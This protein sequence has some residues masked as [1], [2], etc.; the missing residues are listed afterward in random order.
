MSKSVRRNKAAAVAEDWWRALTADQ[1]AGRGARRGAL[2]R[3]RRAVTPLEVMQ[4]PEALRLIARLPR[5]PERV[6]TLAGILAYVRET[7]G[8]TVARS[9]GRASLDDEKAIL[10]EVRFRRLLQARNDELELLEAMRRIVRLTSG[11]VNVYDLSY[12]V[13]HWGDRVRK[14]WIFDYYGVSESTPSGD[15]PA[16]S[17]AHDTT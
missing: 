9:I 8:R 12:A 7:E 6:A 14:R 4:E 5:N 2:A 3:L 1:S 13:L 11:K 10:S 16:L 17:P 15:H